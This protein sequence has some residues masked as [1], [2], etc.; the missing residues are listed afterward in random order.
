MKDK[1]FHFKN[2]FKTKNK[3]SVTSNKSRIN[4]FKYFINLKS[5]LKNSTKTIHVLDKDY[6]L[7]FKTYKLKKFLKFKTIAIIGMGGSILGTE[8]IYNIFKDKINKNI[9]HG[10]RIK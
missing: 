1:D 10:L 8:A 9:Y 4:F 2:N 5:D 6:N 3:F 7:D